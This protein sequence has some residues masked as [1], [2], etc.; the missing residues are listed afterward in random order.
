MRF[1][2]ESSIVLSPEAL[3]SDLSSARELGKVRLGQECVYFTKFSGT[4]YLPYGQVAGA[5]LRQEEV[6]ANL[7]CGRAN[8]D[9][10][11]LMVQCREGKLL[12]A[13]VPNKDLGK[14]ALSLLSAANPDIEIGYKKQG[15]S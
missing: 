5:W 9:Q 15:A 11:F 14:E 12:K 3:A 8:F 1:K 13:E 7:C 4:G 2:A 6:N 10:F